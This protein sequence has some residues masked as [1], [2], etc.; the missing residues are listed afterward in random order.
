MK[1]QHS[2]PL[3]IYTAIYNKVSGR[4]VEITP[5]YASC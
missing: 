2:P 5:P 3:G 4:N 1:M